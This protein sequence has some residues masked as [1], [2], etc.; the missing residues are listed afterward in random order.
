MYIA[1]CSA[2]AAAL[3]WSFGGLISTTPARAL[4]AVRF[5]RIS[6][7]IVSFVLIG[8]V[9]VTGSWQTLG[10]HSALILILSAMIGVFLGESLPLAT[11]VGCFLIMV[12]VMMAVFS[13]RRSL[14]THTFEQVQ[15]SLS[16]GI[17]LGFLAAFCQA[18]AV[19]IARPIMASGVDAVAASALRVGTAA[20]ALNL[21]FLMQPTRGNQPVTPMTRRLMVQTGLSGM[22]GSALGMTLLLFALAHGPAGL[23]STLSATFPVLIL[24]ILWIATKERPATLRLDRGIS[25]GDRLAMPVNVCRY[26]TLNLVTIALSSSARL[27]RSCALNF[28]SL[29]LA[30]ILR[31][32]SETSAISWVI[33]AE[34]TELW[35]TFSFTS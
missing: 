35:L 16:S 2:L 21:L 17:V 25:R 7:S 6:L 9:L 14:S 28:T 26:H 12:G 33:L 19:L 31:E 8:I 4:G 13:G 24:P 11:A 5:N 18:V 30:D 10:L 20:L 27:K 23:V 32:A 29:L 34:T 15:G 1:E 22:L 3:C